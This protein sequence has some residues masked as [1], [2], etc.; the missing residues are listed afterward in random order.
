[1]AVVSQSAKASQPTKDA[2]SKI[3]NARPPEV[4]LRPPAYSQFFLSQRTA[5]ITDL[6][7]E[8]RSYRSETICY[9]IQFY[10]PISK[11]VLTCEC[12]LGRPPSEGALGLVAR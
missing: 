1:M 11:S 9:A 10:T 2:S 12:S 7:P 4:E 3:L 5:T 6:W 8:K